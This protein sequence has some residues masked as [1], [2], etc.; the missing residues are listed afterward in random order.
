MQHPPYQNE[1]PNELFPAIKQGN[2]E[3]FR[4]FF[5]IYEKRIYGFLYKILR[6]HEDVEELLQVVFV[7]IWENRTTINHELS[8]DAYVF[9]IAKN[10]ALDAL[11]QKV[12][13]LFLEKQLVNKFKAGENA[14]EETDS[15]V[16]N[17][18]RLFIDK[19]MSN[20]PERRRE[21]FKLRYEQ[22]LSYK[23][24]AKRLNISENTVDTQ[25]RRTLNYLRTQLG[26]ELWNVA[27]PLI[28]LFSI[29]RA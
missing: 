19:L 28:V 24:I 4:Q 26:K 29:L 22:E 13:K 23:E 25:I 8:P 16:D 17:D 2:H 6:S 3:A 15:L 10:S 9:K 20:V 18:L 5:D 14:G 1:N 21:I 7:K 12:R 11:R 27:L